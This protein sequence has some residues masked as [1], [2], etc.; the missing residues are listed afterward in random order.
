M[1]FH[2]D[3]MPEQ[4]QRSQQLLI[5]IDYCAL[6]SDLAANWNFVLCTDCNKMEYETYGTKEGGHFE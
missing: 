5:R 4:E 1:L 3:S 2:F 6:Q